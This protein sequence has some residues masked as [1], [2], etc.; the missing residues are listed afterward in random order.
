MVKLNAPQR[1]FPNSPKPSHVARARIDPRNAFNKTAKLPASFTQGAVLL[2]PLSSCD[3][4]S[5]PYY[6]VLSLLLTPGNIEQYASAL[7]AVLD[8]WHASLARSV[9]SRTPWDA[10][11]IRDTVLQFII[12]SVVLLIE[13]LRSHPQHNR[14]N[15]TDQRIY[16]KS[17]KRGLTKPQETQWGESDNHE[18]KMWAVI[19]LQSICQADVLLR[20]NHMV[21]IA[22]TCK[23][24][25]VCSGHKLSLAHKPRS[26]GSECC[27]GL[28]ATK[29]KRAVR[30]AVFF[31]PGFFFSQIIAGP[32]TSCT[33]QCPNNPCGVRISSAL[34]VRVQIASSAENSALKVVQS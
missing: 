19:N 30:S 1:S 13:R 2:P 9:P 7:D 27:F 6:G 28:S 10:P 26:R 14:G 34:P 18:G 21:L 29:C 24:Q 11:G 20:E 32:V 23:C 12:D 5:Y 16:S 31:H 17:Q 25:S 22:R 15:V 4:A 3:I 33:P 8:R